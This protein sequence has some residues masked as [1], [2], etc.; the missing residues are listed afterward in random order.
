M[1]KFVRWLF[2]LETPEQAEEREYRQ[3]VQDYQ[4]WLDRQK[5]ES[6]E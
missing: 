1:I 2:G 5:D 4:D 6:A 3:Y